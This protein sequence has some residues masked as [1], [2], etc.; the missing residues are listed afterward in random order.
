MR[1][2][3]TR[4]PPIR[5][6][7]GGGIREGNLLDLRDPRWLDFTRGHPAA[8]PFHRPE[9]AR[10]I[11]DCYRFR[12]FAMTTT[13]EIGTIRAGLP[14]VE[15]RHLGGR[16]RWVALP[17]TD[18][19]S[20]L[21]STPEEETEL[22]RLTRD[23]AR[24]AGIDRIEVRGPLT[25]APAT[26]HAA[27]RHVLLLDPDPAV[28]YARF[29]ASQ[30]KRNIKRAEREGLTLRTGSRPEDLIDTFYKLHLDTRRRQGVPIQPRRFFRLLWEQVVA[31]GL[32]SVLIAESAGRPIAAAVFLSWN[33]TVVYKFGASDAE[34]WSLRPNHLLIWDAIRRACEEG[35]RWFDFGRTDAGQDGLRN[36]KLSWGAIE[37]PL[38]YRALGGAPE[39]T[40]DPEGAATRLLGALIRR[41]PPLVCR[42]T[43]ELLYRY[44]A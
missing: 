11:A 9:W 17:F 38:V 5:D 18:Q 40:T 7:F 21:L 35:Y 1:D 6:E 27:L 42:V 39:Q 36:F 28:V 44:V 29:H 23:A 34:A 30:V 10:L 20:P 33:G 32:G 43:G 41:S 14:L 15:V 22:I 24:A 19:C 31:P 4:K 2:P 26:G 16:P 3:G 12:P 37:E 8:T 25:G 13:D